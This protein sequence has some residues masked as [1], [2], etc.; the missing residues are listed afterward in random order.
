MRV[1]LYSKNCSSAWFSSPFAVRL[2]SR[3][4]WDK[5]SGYQG[6]KFKEGNPNTN[7]YGVDYIETRRVYILLCILVNIENR[8]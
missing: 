4:S 1:A 8:G 2:K 5:T 7:P 3:G 6:K